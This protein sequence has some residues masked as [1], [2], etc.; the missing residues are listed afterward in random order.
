[1][2]DFPEVEYRSGRLLDRNGSWLANLRML[3]ASRARGDPFAA[4][5]GDFRAAATIRDERLKAHLRELSARAAA[6]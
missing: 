6:R 5:P 3:Y 1:V 2:D 4:Y